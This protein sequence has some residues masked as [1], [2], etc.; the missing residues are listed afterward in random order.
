V[1]KGIRKGV[2]GNPWGKREG[3][4]AV[5][6]KGGLE[7]QMEIEERPQK[8]KGTPRRRSAEG[9][10]WGYGSSRNERTPERSPPNS[11]CELKEK[12]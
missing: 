9:E 5:V 6:F 10:D 8:G 12:G 11:Y 2:R 3:G 7:N 1:S 4:P